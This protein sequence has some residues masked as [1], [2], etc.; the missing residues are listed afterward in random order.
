MVRF[1]RGPPWFDTASCSDLAKTCACVAIPWLTLIETERGLPKRHS[2]D[3]TFLRQVIRK[4]EHDVMA[5]PPDPEAI[6]AH[7]PVICDRGAREKF[8][9]KMRRARKKKVFE[10]EA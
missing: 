3:R 2:L 1:H 8:E 6:W 7:G 10:S 9:R 5:R 4:I